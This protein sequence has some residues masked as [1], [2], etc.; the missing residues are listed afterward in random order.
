MTRAERY[1]RALKEM[2]ILDRSQVAC[3]VADAFCCASTVDWIHTMPDFLANAL[4][5]IEIA[6]RNS[7]LRKVKP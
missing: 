1:E 2:T 6:T 5:D 4:N 7:A 3:A